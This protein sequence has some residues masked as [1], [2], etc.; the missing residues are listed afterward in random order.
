M[1]KRARGSVRPG[2]RRPIDR[3]SAPS[4][5]SASSG[6]ATERAPKSSGLSESEL[7]RAAEIE[8]ELLAQERAAETARTRARERA[9]TREVVSSGPV[10]SLAQARSEYAYVARDVKDIV[11]IAALEIG[12]LLA[13]W[14]LIDVTHVI[15]LG[16]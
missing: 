9:A 3:R 11:R 6:P 13:L 5:P 8:A 4:A 1:A 16:A 10:G 7:A 12:I 14:V 15:P 2:R